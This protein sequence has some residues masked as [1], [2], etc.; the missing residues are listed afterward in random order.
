[1]D[2]KLN[3]EQREFPEKVR[4]FSREVI[5]PMAA[6]HDANESVP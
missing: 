2:F 1:M 3:D 6:E 5:R 4:R